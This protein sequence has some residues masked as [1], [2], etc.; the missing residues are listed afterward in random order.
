MST[1]T[2]IA[3]LTA[4]AVSLC[5]QHK[6]RSTQ[7]LQNANPHV[8]VLLSAQMNRAMSAQ[9]QRCLLSSA[10]STQVTAYSAH[11]CL[12][13]R[14]SEQ[15]GNACRLHRLA[16]QD[17]CRNPLQNHD[18]LGTSNFLAHRISPSVLQHKTGRE[19]QRCTVTRA[20]GLTRP[21]D[22]ALWA[23]CTKCHES[24][25][26]LL[27]AA[28]TNLS[29]AFHLSS[30][31]PPSHSCIVKHSVASCTCSIAPRTQKGQ[32]LGQHQG[33]SFEDAHNRRGIKTNSGAV[34]GNH[35]PHT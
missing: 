32:H 34:T 2:R 27:S 8:N 14:G 17:P 21:A 29:A 10:T 23:V 26:D 25:S 24:L 28:S 9:P 11:R 1:T 3:R 33:P 18:R 30:R 6:H 12:G 5:T 35:T 31:P 20:D 13:A 16:T 4:S 19:G 15:P 22:T 7:A